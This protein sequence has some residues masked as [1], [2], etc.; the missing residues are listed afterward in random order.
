MIELPNC[1][2]AFA[3]QILQLPAMQNPQSAAVVL[4][5]SLLLQVSRGRGDGK[6]HLKDMLP[7][8]LVA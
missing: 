8:E 4:D 5:N 3:H 7:H 6:L 2:V 1:G